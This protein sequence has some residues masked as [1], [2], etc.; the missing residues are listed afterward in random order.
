MRCP[1]VTIAAAALFVLASP[2]LGRPAIADTSSS[3]VLIVTGE[4]K[5]HD[6]RRT[7]P[8][9]VELL[10]GDPR[11]RVDVLSDL[12]S[13]RTIDLKSYDVVVIHFKNER[14]YGI[15]TA[16]EILIQSL[17]VSVVNAT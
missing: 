5:H 1:Q 2:V 17:L 16:G 14:A 10:H 3:R 8:V 11:L 4:D 12:A 9:L 15:R 13:L 7:T 6:W